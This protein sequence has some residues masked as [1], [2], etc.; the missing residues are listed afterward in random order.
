[1]AM[2]ISPKIERELGDVLAQKTL[3][4]LK[5]NKLLASPGIESSRTTGKKAKRRRRKPADAAAA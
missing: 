4:F 1:M 3:T 5:K 2:N